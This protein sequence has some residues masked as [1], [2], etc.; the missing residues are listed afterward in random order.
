MTAATTISG[1]SSLQ[2][3]QAFVALEQRARAAESVMELA[4]ILANETISLIHFSQAAVLEANGKVLCLSG[5]S[6][7]DERSPFALFLSRLVSS[8]QQA[9][10]VPLKLEKDDLEEAL[11]NEWDEWL[12]PNAVWVPG[13]KL[14]WA[15]LVAR[16]EP[17]T[18]MEIGWLSRLSEAFGHA[19]RALLARRRFR[20]WRWPSLSVKFGLAALIALTLAA[21]IRLTV[22]APAEIVAINPTIIRSPI[23][24]VIDKILVQPN[25]AVEAGR[26]LVDLDTTTLSGKLDVAMKDLVAAQAEYR[27]TMQLA[28]S[29]PKARA[30][31]AAIDGRIEMRASEITY[32]RAM[33]EKARLTAPISGIVIFDDPTELI[34]RPVTVGEKI[35]GIT[36]AKD[37]EIEAWVG[38][39]DAIDLPQGA[40]VMLVLN[41]EPLSPVY[42]QV[43]YRA[44]EALARPDGTTGYRL[45]ATLAQGA[46]PPRLGLRG[47]LRLEGDRVTIAYWLMRR[48]LA[49]LRQA[50]GV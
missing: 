9:G 31:L 2:D 47:T 33:L 44:Y 49:A 13:G 40:N 29:E 36:E 28:V 3:L 22:L 24:A 50:L 7:P 32:L 35:I 8:V 26:R 43:R 1:T 27:Q 4:F 21:P 20:S 38:L 10:D 15:F 16:D 37:V 6:L 18:E 46:P 30:Q 25:E 5:V 48:P 11:R 23:D 42:G 34:G 45:R 12:L 19:H 41:A 39:G 14:G 17:F